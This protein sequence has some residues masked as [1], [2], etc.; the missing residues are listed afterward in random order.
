MSLKIFLA[1]LESNIDFGKAFGG[2]DIIEVNLSFTRA[3]VSFVHGEVAMSKTLDHQIIP[4]TSQAVTDVMCLIF[5]LFESLDFASL[6]ISIISF[7]LLL[8][9]SS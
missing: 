2:F 6:I 1:V 4:S 8:L 3:T 7:S 9:I 5:C